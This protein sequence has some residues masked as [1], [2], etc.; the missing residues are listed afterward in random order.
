MHDHD[1]KTPGTKRTWAVGTNIPAP[2]P[3]PRW[4]VHT[5]N[6]QGGTVFSAIVAVDQMGDVIQFAMQGLFNAPFVDYDNG[7]VPG[8]GTKLTIEKVS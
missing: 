3:S 6:E 5:E 4:R 7:W 2:P 8:P 1:S